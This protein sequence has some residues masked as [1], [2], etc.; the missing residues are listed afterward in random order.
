MT[1]SDTVFAILN[2]AFFGHFATRYRSGDPMRC[3]AWLTG[4]QLVYDLF[5]VGGLG[6]SSP[7]TALRPA[8][9]AV[10]TLFLARHLIQRIK[11]APDSV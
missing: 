1:N 11:R 7:A 5:R 8:T 2:A 9:M 6:D 4:G 3:V 10:A